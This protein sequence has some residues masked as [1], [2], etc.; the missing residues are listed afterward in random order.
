MPRNGVW[1]NAV[2]ARR[3]GGAI[4][5][6][7]YGNDWLVG[8]VTKRGQLDTAFGVGGWAVLPFPGEITQA[9]QEPSGRIVVAGD[10]GGGG[11]CTRNWAAA[12]SAR[13]RLDRRFGANGRTELPTGGDSGV[14]LVLLEP[15]G[16]ILFQVVYGNNGCWGVELSMLLASGR[17]VARF[18]TRMQRFW[19]RQPFQLPGGAS[20]FVG[21]VYV[22]GNGFTLVGTGQNQC[23]GYPLP[24]GQSPTGLIARFRVDGRPVSARRFA[25][26]MSGSIQAFREGKEVFVVTAS[27]FDQT[28]LTV[29]ARRL[30]GSID[31]RF[32][33][34]G[35]ARIG[36]PWKGRGAAL[37]TMV[38]VNRAAPKVLVVVATRDGGKQMQLIRIRL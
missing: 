12:L 21:R 23:Y 35:T 25:S 30:D 26:H 36:T 7:T 14:D 1:V 19:K 6:G 32:G 24:R 18:A 3:D 15:D 22:D 20:A 13:G 28:H 33:R 10:D 5:A 11:C 27:Y 4:L 34:R 29:T 17:P 9:V 37:E 31:S 38:F 8:E 2:A 16:H